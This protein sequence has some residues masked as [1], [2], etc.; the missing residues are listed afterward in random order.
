MRHTFPRE[1]YI[2]KGAEKLDCGNTG[3]EIYIGKT[4]RGAVHIVAFHGKA[5]K[6]AINETWRR[7]EGAAKRVA[8][9]LGNLRARATYKAEQKAKRAAFVHNVQVGDIYRTSWGYDQT[10]VEFFEVVEVRGKYAILREIACAVGEQGGPSERV[11]PQSG[12]FLEPRYAGDDQGLPIR[13]LIQEGR[14]KISDVRTAWPWGKRVAGVVVGE[15]CHR[16]GF[17]YGH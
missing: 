6:P 9:Y 17:G 16:T 3:A 14:I 15:S 11:V 8:D 10:N 5:Q 4:A 13:R 1:F 2:P 7:P 12:A